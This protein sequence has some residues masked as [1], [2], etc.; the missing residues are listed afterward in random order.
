MYQLAGVRMES[1]LL[2]I[3]NY[4]WTNSTHMANL[5]RVINSVRFVA[6]YKYTQ[7]TI[8]ISLITVQVVLYNTRFESLH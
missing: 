4:M 5:Q 6:Y 8:V 7:V 2:G 1:F 3:E